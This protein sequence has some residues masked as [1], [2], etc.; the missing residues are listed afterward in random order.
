MPTEPNEVLQ[1]GENVSKED[2]RDYLDNLQS[3]V[4]TSAEEAANLAADTA[5]QRAE[6][7][8]NFS[9]LHAGIGLHAR[10]WLEVSSHMGVE[11]DY[12]LV[13]TSDAGVHLDPI[14]VQ[15][16]S[17]SGIYRWS[18]D[19]LGSA[20]AEWVHPFELVSKVS[21]QNGGTYPGEEVGVS[22]EDGQGN[23]AL[24]ATDRRLSTPVID[25]TPDTIDHP[26]ID[27]LLARQDVEES[28]PGAGGVEITD[29]AGNTVLSATSSRF[30]VS[31]MSVTPDKIDHPQMAEVAATST[32]LKRAH[33]PSYATQEARAANAQ[34]SLT[35]QILHIMT[36]GQSLSVGASGGAGVL[37]NT[38]LTYAQTFVGGPAWARYPAG[39]ND[40]SYIDEV[41]ASLVPFAEGIADH[42]DESPSGGIA[43]MM[44]QMAVEDGWEF[45]SGHAPGLML[46]APGS[47]GTSVADLSTAPEFDFPLADID[48]AIDLF[49]AQGETVMMSVMPVIQGESDTY[50]N[51]QEWMAGWIAYKAAIEAHLAAKHNA[52]CAVFSPIYQMSRQHDHNPRTTMLAQLELAQQDGWA[53][54]TPIYFLEK[55]ADGTHLTALSSLWM[56][57]FFGRCIY[58]KIFK[59]IDRKPVIP[60][61]HRRF[62]NALSVQFQIADGLELRWNTDQVPVATNYGFELV[63]ADGVTPLAITDVTLIGH[64]TVQ[65]MSDAP[66]PVGAFLRYAWSGDG[67][68]GAD[69][70]RA[71]GFG[72]LQDTDP[73]I[74]D[75]NGHALSLANW[76]PI[77]EMEI[78]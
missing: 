15:G 70:L 31:T 68:A 52:P 25:V 21:T 24:V 65:I 19:G 47:A 76:A 41:H 72:N 74:F 5:T 2:F 18:A 10:T 12:A 4:Q 20:Q 73:E 75:P 51:P 78:E 1:D 46:S 3:T 30:S 17:N 36:T 53:L 28:Y 11:G 22:L 40:Q 14:T 16:V 38:P 43:R 66:V 61:A 35:A 34:F 77:F 44:Q 69:N 37:T 57:A 54:A 67:T 45:G 9:E 23:P 39:N 59:G 62:G 8:A 48:A 6:A 29:E 32:L 56:G 63:A 71:Y 49:G 7:A 64:D 13:P 42:R 26:V 60:A 50:A 58:D 33:R 55:V 27:E